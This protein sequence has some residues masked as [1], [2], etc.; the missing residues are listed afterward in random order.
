VR[1]FID[2]HAA[3]FALLVFHLAAECFGLSWECFAELGDN[4]ELLKGIFNGQDLFCCP[5]LIG[6]PARRYVLLVLL[7]RS[8][9]KQQHQNYFA[10]A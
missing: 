4:C 9:E 6:L 5:F 7:A 3:F 10:A 1:A 8:E 2:S